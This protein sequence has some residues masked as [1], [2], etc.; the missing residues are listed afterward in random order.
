MTD[1]DESAVSSV[2]ELFDDK[3][4]GLPALTFVGSLVE[5]KEG[6]PLDMDVMIYLVDLDDS[7]KSDVLAILREHG[8]I[9]HVNGQWLVTSLGEQAFKNS[10]GF[11]ALNPNE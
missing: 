10:F 5:T 11:G 8:A 7:V 9:D 2:I 6:R 4:L 1:H 3:E